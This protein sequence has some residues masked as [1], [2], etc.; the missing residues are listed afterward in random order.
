MVPGLSRERRKF[1]YWL[2]YAMGAPAAMFVLTICLNNSDHVIPD[3][4]H[5][6]IGNYSCW[7]Q[8]GKYT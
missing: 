6:R 2:I 1:C 5:P 7:F 4:L 8:G 3:D